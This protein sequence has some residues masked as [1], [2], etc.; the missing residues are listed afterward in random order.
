MCF[1]T[2]GP[3]QQGPQLRACPLKLGARISIFSL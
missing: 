3:K 2:R 1:L